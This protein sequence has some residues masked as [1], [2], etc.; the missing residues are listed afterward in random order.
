MLP[1]LCR[2][3]YSG[4]IV[5]KGLSCSIQTL[6]EKEAKSTNTEAKK[7]RPTFQ[8]TINSTKR[9]ITVICTIC[10]KNSPLS[11]HLSQANCHFLQ[12]TQVYD[13]FVVRTNIQHYLVRFLQL[14]S[15]INKQK[16]SN[17]SI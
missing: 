14:I 1:A 6:Q 10:E 8:P 16:S 17:F 12:H 7:H 9:N 11:E 3:N 4:L 15:Q 5:F 2:I 13:K